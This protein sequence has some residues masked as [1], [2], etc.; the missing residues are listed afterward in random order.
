MSC[1]KMANKHFSNRYLRSDTE[2]KSQLK[3]AFRFSKVRI[4]RTVSDKRLKSKM[5]QNMCRQHLSP[6]KRS[7]ISISLVHVTLIERFSYEC[8]KTKRNVITTA[9]QKK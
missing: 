1:E 2:F 7:F 5:T 3:M 9:N 4:P 6:L 8:R